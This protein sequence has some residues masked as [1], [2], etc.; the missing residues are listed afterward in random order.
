T[1][2][3]NGKLYRLTGNG[4]VVIHDSL[5]R[6]VYHLQADIDDDGQPEIVVCEYGNYSGV[7][8]LLD[9]DGRGGYTYRRL[10]G[11]AGAIR[12][13]ADDLN[14][15]GLTDLIVL[16]AQGDEGIDVLYQGTDQS[17][18][19]ETLLRFPA[20]WGT[21]WFELVDMDGDGDRDIVT[22]HGDNADYSNIIK[23]YHGVRIYTNDG[24]NSFTETFFQPLPGATRVA[25]R[26]FDGDGDIDLAVAC[27][28]ADYLRQP[29]A[30]FVYLDQVTPS[31]AIAFRPSTTP[32]ALEGRWLILEAGDY[33]N[34]GD[35]D[36]ALGSFTLNPA[37]V[38]DSLAQRWR[39]SRTDVLLL[40]N[41]FRPAR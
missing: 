21:S 29:E 28:F 41:T 12:V 25:A 6:P 31:P 14:A 33:D 32:V 2:A 35:E 19:R 17:F 11:T 37:P 22:A 20:V 3:S 23:P 10:L 7:L 1:E 4:P 9:P 38:P 5:H 26:D 27:N 30:S 40:E 13:V 8:S 34:D 18:A 24:E 36:I 15:D 39:D 16:H